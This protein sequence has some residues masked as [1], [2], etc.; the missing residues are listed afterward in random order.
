MK[1]LPNSMSWRFSLMF[2][3]K[4][5]V[6]LALKFWCCCKWNCLLFFSFLSLFLSSFLPPSFPTFLPSWV[7]KKGIFLKTKV[8]TVKGVL[9]RKLR[10]WC[11]AWEDS[12]THAMR[13]LSLTSTVEVLEACSGWDQTKNAN[14]RPKPAGVFQS[15]RRGYCREKH[16]QSCNLFASSRRELYVL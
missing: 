6:V 14:V 16:R 3:S 13:T 5:S 7:L 8:T 10:K 15:D 4:N 12:Y 9:K 2:S 1:L 11:F